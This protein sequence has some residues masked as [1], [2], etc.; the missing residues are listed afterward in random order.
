MNQ[1]LSTI[2][3]EVQELRLF[4]QE[5]P[6]EASD[7]AISYFEDYL[8]L[9]CQYRKLKNNLEK[10]QQGSLEI[11]TIP[12]PAFVDSSLSLEQEFRVACL[13][14]YLNKHPS[15][16]ETFAI[17]YFEDFLHLVIQYQKLETQLLA[18]CCELE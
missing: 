3:S 6:E 12:K 5:Y 8:I 16:S 17:S 18:Y 14:V 7:L 2:E 10:L 13:K 15:E 4:L 11:T 9:F 1:K